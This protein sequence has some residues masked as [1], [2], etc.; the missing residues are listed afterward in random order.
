M[1]GEEVLYILLGASLQAAGLQV[2]AEDGSGEVHD[3]NFLETSLQIPGGCVRHTTKG[4]TSG[5]DKVSDDSD[6]EV[7]NS[8]N[9]RVIMKDTFCWGRTNTVMPFP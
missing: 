8:G 4:D 1:V 3:K 2:V 9:S 6:L 7:E 5:E